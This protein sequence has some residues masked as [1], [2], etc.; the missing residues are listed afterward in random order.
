M[1]SANSLSLI[2]RRL[3][4]VESKLNRMLEELRTLNTRPPP[5]AIRCAGA[6]FQGRIERSAKLVPA[7]NGWGLFRPRDKACLG[8]ETLKALEAAMAIREH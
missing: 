3:D 6:I 4:E 5:S 1:T 2:L 8:D 7:S